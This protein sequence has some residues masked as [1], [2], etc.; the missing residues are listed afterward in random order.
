MTFK[1]QKNITNR[2]A[3]AIIARLHP[4]FKETNL[5]ERDWSREYLDFAKNHGIL[6][7][8]NIDKDLDEN[9]TRKIAFYMIYN[10]DREI[11]NIIEEIVRNAMKNVK[12]DESSPKYTYDNN[13]QKR[14]SRGE[15][16][17]KNIVRF[18]DKDKLL[19]KRYFYDGEYLTYI[20]APEKDGYNFVAWYKE[21]KRVDFPFK[22]FS[23][24]S[25]NAKYEKVKSNEDDYIEDLQNLL[26]YDLLLSEDIDKANEEILKSYKTSFYYAKNL[27][28]DIS[29]GKDVDLKTIKSAILNLNIAT[30]NLKT[31]LKKLNSNEESVES[32]RV[33]SKKHKTKYEVGDALDLNGLTIEVKN[34]DGSVRTMEVTDDMVGGFDSNNP[35]K[36]QIL[37]I[38][39]KGKTTSYNIKIVEKEPKAEIVWIKV[40]SDNHK[41]EYKV[42]EKLDTKNLKILIK[43]EDYSLEEVDVT[44][45][46]IEGFDSSKSINIKKLTINYEDKNAT[47]DIKVLGE[48]NSNIP[49]LKSIRVDNKEIDGFNTAIKNY[50]VELDE[51]SVPVIVATPEDEEKVTKEVINAKDLKD[52]NVTTVKLTAEDGSTNVYTVTFIKKPEIINSKNKYLKTIKVGDEII[53][54]SHDKVIYKVNLKKGEEL[55]LVDGVPEDIK[56][57]VKIVQAKDTVGKDYASIQVISEKGNVLGGYTVKFYFSWD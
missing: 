21:G 55:P 11:D 1:P 20:N 41:I 12:E 26:D 3:V 24:L 19:F 32:I 6:D 18:Y 57:T 40:I 28:K 49:K 29:D 42:N 45:D 38:T 33:N 43:R 27:L 36:S 50:V 31:E 13:L 35:K 8:L 54:A 25:L 52:K 5:D 39:Y 48:E 37:T 51:S 16:K 10:Y 4:D 7:E 2:E 53:K 34:S 56:N 15:S 17:N 23:D 22:V 14:S 30:D 47:Y 9:A 44:P 46:M